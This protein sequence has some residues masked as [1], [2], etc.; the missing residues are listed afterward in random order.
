MS[1]ILVVIGLIIT[2]LVLQVSRAPEQRVIQQ[3]LPNAA[4]QS[5]DKRMRHRHMW[6]RFDFFNIKHA[7]IGF[8]PMILK[9]RIIILETAVGREKDVQDIDVH[10]EF[11]KRVATLLVM[12]AFS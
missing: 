4:D 12:S 3:L 6:N 8:P 5:F 2:K 7:Q 11:G 1:S 10:G 9:Q